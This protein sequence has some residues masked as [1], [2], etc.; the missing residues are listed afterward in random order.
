MNAWTAYTSS[1]RARWWRGEQRTCCHCAHAW[2]SHASPPLSHL[3]SPRLLPA[4]PVY[5]HSGNSNEDEDDARH[6]A[7]S[8]LN[9]DCFLLG[10]LPMGTLAAADEE[11]GGPERNGSYRKPARGS[12][13][14]STT[15]RGEEERRGEAASSAAPGPRSAASD[16]VAGGRNVSFQTLVDK[17]EALLEKEA[18][19]LYEPSLCRSLPNRRHRPQSL[20]VS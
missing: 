7:G 17:K 8:I 20:A 4:P 3:T 6:P 15:A 5:V 14:A 12:D 18:C 19:C 11:S 10:K 13:W 9:A 1:S 2:P 16:A